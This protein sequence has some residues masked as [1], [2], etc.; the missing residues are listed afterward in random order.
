MLSLDDREWYAF[1]YNKVFDD[2]QRG[3][4]LK[5]A[6]H[7][8]GT[9][10]YISSSAMCNG[11]DDFVG[12]DSSVRKFSDCLTV[13]NSGSVGTVF[14]HPYEFVASDHVTELKS[15]RFNRYVYLFLSAMASRLT[16]KYN[17][18]REINETRINREFIL[19]PVDTSGEPDWKFMEDYIRELEGQKKEQYVKYAKQKLA[20]IQYVKIPALEDKNFTPFFISDIFD[21]RA[22]KRLTK[23][24]MIAGIRPFI[25][26]SDSNNGVTSF[27]SNENK[28][29]DSNVLGVNYNGSVCE[30]FY[31]PYECLFSDDVKHLAIKDRTG[32]EYIDLFVKTM[33]VQQ[34]VKYAYGYKFNQARM[35]KQFIMLPTDDNNNLDWFY[36][37]QYTKNI[38]IQ[39][40]TDYLMQAASDMSFSGCQKSTKSK[41]M[42]NYNP[43]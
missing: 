15:K 11:V 7:T 8:H 2:I 23:S 20:E 6:H 29:F 30:A 35:R 40:L 4:R 37:E 10:P 9:T 28:S 18:N 3:K 41:P 39:R 38:T 43:F 34:K 22:G 32:N 16:Q 25:G 31:H 13:A 36:M 24:D 14:Y 27:V 1:L 17:F 33:I 26:A 19:L 21:I 42:E 12:N 5:T